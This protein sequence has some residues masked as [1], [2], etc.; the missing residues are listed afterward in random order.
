MQPL[1]RG[2][3][4]VLSR[5]TLT[6]RPWTAFFDRRT[7]RSV[8]RQPLEIAGRSV[9]IL[10]TRTGFGLAGFVLLLLATATNYGNSL[11]FLLAF[12]LTGLGLV[13]ML[14]TWRNLAGLRVRAG[15][16]RAAFA[17]EAAGYDLWLEAGERERWALRL[18]PDSGPAVSLVR[19]GRQ[20]TQVQLERPAPRRG[21][22]RLGR[23]RLESRFPLGLF[24]AWTW[25]DFDTEALVYPRPLGSGEPPAGS[26]R[27][28]SAEGDAGHGADDFRGYRNYHPGDPPRQIDW[29]A[30][31][32]TDTLWTREFGGDGG[33]HCWLEWAATAGDTERRLSQL[34]RWVLD[35]EAAGLGYGLRLP[36]ATLEPGRGPEQRSRCLRALALFGED[37]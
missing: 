15:A 4:L 35:A 16:T 9:F 37:A 29:K 32:R 36:D 6:T 17:G 27:R 23:V 24:R 21:R 19:V 20:P 13:A 7:P 26:A 12:A 1:V 31:A 34:C 28:P 25:I 18:A 14:E 8:G 3:D 11:V 22:Q 30:F 33:E 2:E 5:P 10:P